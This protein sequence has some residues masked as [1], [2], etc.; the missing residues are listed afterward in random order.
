MR[1]IYQCI[2]TTDSEVISPLR[3]VHFDEIR[4]N[5]VCLS[6]DTGSHR[7]APEQ[8]TYPSP[9]H[10]HWRNDRFTVPVLSP[11]LH[12]DLRHPHVSGDPPHPV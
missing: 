7:D 6:S 1:S 5:T 4:A 3:R 12:Q 11:K 8:I 9:S 2:P 10:D